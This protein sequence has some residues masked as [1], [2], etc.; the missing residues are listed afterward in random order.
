MAD[1]EAIFNDGRKVT[2]AYA[3]K[4]NDGNY[5][6][7]EASVYITE[8]VPED[9]ENILKWVVDNAEHF[10]DTAKAEVWNALGVEFAYDEQGHPH[11]TKPAPAAPPAMPA[12]A[13]APQAPTQ[14][15]QPPPI[16][17]PQQQG[18]RDNPTVAQ[19]GY[20]ADPPSFC[21]ECGNRDFFDNRSDVD[22]RISQGK[23]IGPDF[24]CKNRDCGKGVWRPGSFEYN[25]AVKAGQAG[26]AQ[27]APAPQMPSP[28]PYDPEV[29][30]APF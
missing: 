3:R 20:Y 24:K 13:P 5:G 27:Q 14:Q 30:G 22:Q 18:R 7:E 15:F 26:Q 6:S 10:I 4:L 19:P 21:K 23:R 9:A 16:G 8:F 28:P 12:P 25:E 1:Q 29:D 2:F 17:Q 11:V